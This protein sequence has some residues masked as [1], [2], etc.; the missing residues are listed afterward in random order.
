MEIGLE[1][2]SNTV[3]APS[4]SCGEEGTGVALGPEGDHVRDMGCRVNPAAPAVD[5]WGQRALADRRAVC[6]GSVS[7]DF[8]DLNNDTRLKSIE[9]LDTNRPYMRLTPLFG[10]GFAGGLRFRWISLFNNL[11]PESFKHPEMWSPLHVCGRFLSLS[12]R[13][14]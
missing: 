13:Y 5:T 6:A 4:A 9:A 1:R 14:A 11:R 2:Q 10:L 3:A 7:G 12:H 8:H